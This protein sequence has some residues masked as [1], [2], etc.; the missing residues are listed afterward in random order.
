MNSLRPLETKRILLSEIPWDA[1]DDLGNPLVTPGM[2]GVEFPDK[3]VEVDGDKKT[4][5]MYQI[6]EVW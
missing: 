1:K 2:F 4:V 6:I 3:E 5:R